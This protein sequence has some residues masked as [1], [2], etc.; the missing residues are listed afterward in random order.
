MKPFSPGQ[1]DMDINNHSAV[2][3]SKNPWALALFAVVAVAAV[4]YVPYLVPQAPS[5]SSSWLF[6]YNNRAAVVLTVFFALC[7]AVWTKGD[8][9]VEPGPAPAQRLPKSVLWASLLITAIACAAIYV[10]VAGPGSF[11]ESGYNIHRIWL[12]SLS[13]RPYLDFEWPFGPAQL[14]VPL[15]FHRVFPME[16]PTA[17]FLYWGLTAIAGEALLFASVN[18][19]DFPTQQKKQIFFLLFAATLPF[20]VFTG[21]QYT[22]FRYAAPLYCALKIFDSARQAQGTNA[23][24]RLLALAWLFDA[25]LFLLSPEMATAFSF[26]VLAL[27]LPVPRKNALWPKTP[28]LLYVVLLAGLAALF[29][30]AQHLHEM[31]TAKASAQ[32]QESLPIVLSV[33]L[34]FTF[35]QIA[36]CFC[37]AYRTWRGLRPL[38]NSIAAVLVAVPLLPAALGRA[39]FVHML[40]NC[41]GMTVAALAYASTSKKLWRYF[42][43]AYLLMWVYYVISFG[44]N[45]RNGIVMAENRALRVPYAPTAAT[46]VVDRLDHFVYTHLP[47]GFRAAQI[48]KL[49]QAQ[50]PAMPDH[51]D[52]SA[53]Y[54]GADL[55]P[56]GVL[57]APLGYDPQ[58]VRSFYLSPQVDYGYYRG[59]ENGKILESM[60]RR[61][62]ELKAHP[63]RG[64]LLPGFKVYSVIGDNVEDCRYSDVKAARKELEKLA[65]APYW[66]RPAHIDNP[67]WQFCSYV[68]ANYDKAYGPT[69][70]N[71]GYELWTPKKKDVQ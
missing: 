41:L 10:L 14:Y 53:L 39:D 50:R 18:L 28:V 44:A 20:L 42:A 3:W 4:L 32:G 51:I 55:R 52:F 35:W 46:T 61:I 38:D 16:I 37:V 62:D 70:Q 60:A 31:D 13:K 2:S 29:L 15:W 69:P 23:W 27:L 64:V 36:L 5:G 68:L 7:A 65:L 19:I 17:A 58:R 40:E 30:C 24:L 67:F 11:A 48:R 66:R 59:D 56:N 54:P 1:R 43:G 63:E 22:V 26:A 71:G 12:L 49:E 25:G 57:M 21:A 8:V 33:V 9:I 6:G 45:L 47:A 34:L